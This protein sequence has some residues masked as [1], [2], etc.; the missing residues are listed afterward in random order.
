MCENIQESME[1]AK[2]SRLGIDYTIERWL[3]GPYLLVCGHYDESRE[4]LN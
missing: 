4:W 1:I 3:Y 2:E